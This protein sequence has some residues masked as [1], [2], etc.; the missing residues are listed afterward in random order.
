MSNSTYKEANNWLAE[1]FRCVRFREH[2]LASNLFLEEGCWRDLL[3]FSWNIITVE[4][5]K[6]VVDMLKAT[7]N[8]VS[9]AEWEIERSSLIGQDGDSYW[10][11]F[12]TSIANCKGKLTLKGGK[13]SVLFT[14]VDELIGHEEATLTRRKKGYINK[15]IKGRKTWLDERIEEEK[16]LGYSEQP[17]VVVVGGG[18]GGIGLA[19]RLKVLGVPTIV[20]DKN[21]RPGDSWR[22]R[23]HSLYLRNTV[24]QDQMPYLDFPDDWP[25]FMSKDRMGDWLEMYVRIM[26]IN[27]WSSTICMGAKYSEELEH[28][29]VDLKRFGKVV[30]LRP[31]HLVIATG[32]SGNPKV[33]EIE[34]IRSFNGVVCHSSGF[35]SGKKFGAKKCVVVG[36]NN[37]AHDICMDL[38]EH[39]ADVTMVQRSET[40]VVRS[41]TFFSHSKYTQA[42]ADSEVTTADLDLMGASIPYQ[43]MREQMR[44]AWSEIANSDRDYYDSLVDAGFLLTFGEDNTGLEMMYMYR[45]SGYYIDVGATELLVAGLVKLRSGVTIQYIEGRVMMLS[46]GTKI[47]ADL[48]VFATGYQPMSTWVSKLI[49]P[50][51]ADKIGE[52]WGLGSDTKY[53]PGPWEGE[54]RNMW[55]P[56]ACAGL[57]FHGGGLTQSRLYSRFLAMQLKARME[58]IPTPVYSL[59]KI[60]DL[61]L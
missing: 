58:N 46:D 31:K 13:C 16:E 45:G 37:S 15:A 41:E 47:E 55:K 5:K 48:I 39:G 60:N 3:A 49:S 17:Y 4:G 22:N 42:A 2:H 18:Q 53:D 50:E 35:D 7:S 44:S 43:I 19:A 51:M 38:W 52:C 26:E 29:T 8:R 20:V 57:W 56:T 10:F 24:W 6:D 40:L 33:P 9:V 36:S 32:M 23:Y 59:E 30:Q 34:G 11:T 25:V 54:L 28:W 12:S 61:Q 14:S 27:Y 1:F 21:E